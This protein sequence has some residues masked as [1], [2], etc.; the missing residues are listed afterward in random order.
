ME[1]VSR[2]AECEQTIAALLAAGQNVS[3]YAQLRGMGYGCST[4]TRALR[5]YPDL[6]SV[7]T[8]HNSRRWE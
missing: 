4:I 5:A 6:R 1:R 8:G 2:V 7:E 3:V